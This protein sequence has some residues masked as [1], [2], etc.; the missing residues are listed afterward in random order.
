MKLRVFGSW[1]VMIALLASGPCFGGSLYSDE[2]YESLV[3]SQRSHRVGESL[4]VL[5]FEQASA[6]A[7]A[8]TDTN[9][10]L[11]VAG[12][13][14]AD[15][16]RHEAALGISNDFA[17]GGTINRSAELF[18]SVSVTIEEIM[19]SGELKVRGEQLIEVNDEIQRIAVSGRVRLQDISAQNTVPSTRLADANITYVG[20]GLLGDRQAP[21]ILTRF[22]NWLF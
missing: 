21:G 22:F 6:E 1:S 13:A 17:G 7:S 3:A 4:T 9:K 14:S 11:D 19:P 5:I 10:S 15:S 16:T 20:D 18:A 12:R 8:D 2:R